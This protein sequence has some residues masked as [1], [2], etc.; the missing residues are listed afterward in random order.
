MRREEGEKWTGLMNTMPQSDNPIFKAKAKS[1][2]PRVLLSIK[3]KK[4]KPKQ[5]KKDINC[6]LFAVHSEK[7]VKMTNLKYVCYFPEMWSSAGARQFFAQNL[8]SSPLQ[9]GLQYFLQ[10]RFPEQ[11]D[12]LESCLAFLKTAEPKPL[13]MNTL[14]SREGRRTCST[15]W[16]AAKLFF[17]SSRIALSPWRL[18]WCRGARGNSRNQ[19]N[20]HQNI[21]A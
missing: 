16:Q 18:N 12:Q 17:F 3:K 4:K 1:L 2:Y 8:N 15:A 21:S 14:N 13:T 11:T 19:R 5:N 6:R 7:V 20:P 9:F 10:Q